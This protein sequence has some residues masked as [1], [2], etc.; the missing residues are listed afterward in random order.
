MKTLKH[1]LRKSIPGA[2][3]FAAL[4]LLSTVAPAATLDATYNATTDV[5]VTAS[6]Y[7][8]TGNTVNFTLN[9]ASDTGTDLMVVQNAG[10]DFIQGT[11]TNLTNGQPVAL[12]YGGTAYSFVANYC[13][14]TG[15]DLVLV[16]ADTRPFAWGQNVSGHLGDNT[17]TARRVPVPLT[18]LGVLAGKTVIAIAAGGSAPNSLS[19]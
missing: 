2:V 8:A 6:G 7:T 3:A 16:W 10:L 9:F 1:Y 5:P 13:G 11:F 19:K 18:A 17:T 15:N 12:S 4:N 14:G